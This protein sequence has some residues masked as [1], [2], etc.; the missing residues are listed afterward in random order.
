[1][2]TLFVPDQ[3]KVISV[4]SEH[5]E[6]VCPEKGDRVSVDKP[7]YVYCAVVAAVLS[8]W[9]TRLFS[10]GELS[11][12]GRERNKISHKGSLGMRMMPKLRIHA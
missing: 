6:P 3:D 10:M 9:R 8:V 11:N 7:L 4:A 2:C 1:M 12:G 5:L